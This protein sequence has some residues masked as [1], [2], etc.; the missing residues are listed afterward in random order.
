[1]RAAYLGPPGTFCEV[2]LRMLLGD[3]A[4]AVPVRSEREAILAVEDG[5]LEGAVVPIENALEGAVTGTLDALALETRR[6]R[7]VAEA[8]VA[9]EHVLT[10]ERLE[11]AREVVSHP[12]ALAQCRR[13]I[14]SELPDAAER[15]ATSTAAAVRDLRPG[16]VAIATARAA[17]LYGRPVLR[18]GIEDE[19]GNATRFVQ[20]ARDPAAV[21]GADRTTVVFH[22]GDDERPGWLVGCLDEFARRGVSLTKIESRPRKVGLGHYLFVLTC[23]GAAGDPGVE[24]ALAGLS[25]RCESVRVLGSYRAAPG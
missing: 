22:G 4:D 5:E 7:I 25:P 1:M 14:A 6:T 20:L 9:V 13:F 24:A 18:T 2:A 3:G 8:V 19:P 21:P 16:Q 17:E 12:Q 11:D 23:A 10:G 15:A